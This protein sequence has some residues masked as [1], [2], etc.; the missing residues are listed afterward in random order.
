MLG[1][2]TAKYAKSAKDTERLGWFRGHKLGTGFL[3]N[4]ADGE[5]ALLLLCEVGL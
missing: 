5:S 2:G 3:Y 1:D 4:G